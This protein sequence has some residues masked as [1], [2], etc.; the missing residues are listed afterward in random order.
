MKEVKVQKDGIIK[1]INEAHLSIY[2]DQGWKKVEE[3]LSYFS[4][5]FTKI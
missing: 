3:N 5:P 1:T 2:L 4:S